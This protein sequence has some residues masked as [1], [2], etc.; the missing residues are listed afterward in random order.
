MR[1]KSWAAAAPPTCK[2]QLENLMKI[3]HKPVLLVALLVGTTISQAALVSRGGG[4]VY[5]TT[6]NITWLTDWN[7]AKTSGYH[8]DGAMD[9]ASAKAWA[10]Q[11]VVGGYDDWRLPSAQHSAGGSVCGPAFDCTDSEM[12]HMFY[13]NW[14]ATRGQDF[15]TG[16]DVA[17]L[18]LF[19][20]VQAGPYWTGTE[21]GP[22]PGSAWFFYTAS[23][24]GF[25]TYVSKRP[26]LF[27]V[28]V[29]VGD[30]PEPQSAALA[31]LGLGALVLTA[32]RRRP[33][34]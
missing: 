32:K 4:M 15:F 8:A 21:Y 12:G 3:L 9:W 17:N 18:A 30:V 16:S 23:S 33:P 25:Q 19:S 29:R 2:F 27:A 31:L 7:Y 11:L 22:D 1:F 10:D 14:G 6:F 34:A 28:A 20:N 24:G 13:E 5:D 26:P